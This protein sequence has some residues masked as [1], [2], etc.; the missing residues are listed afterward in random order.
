MQHFDFIVCIVA[1]PAPVRLAP[2]AEL[3]L[4]DLTHYHLIE[5]EAYRYPVSSPVVDFFKQN[6]WKRFHFEKIL[7]G[8]YR[9]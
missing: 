6:F 9:K 4:P 7:W 1:I 2:S 8:K 3:Q 5:R